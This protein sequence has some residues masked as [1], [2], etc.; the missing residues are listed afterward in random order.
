MKSILPHRLP[1]ISRPPLPDTGRRPP[2]CLLFPSH[3]RRRLASLFFLPEQGPF[4]RLQARTP[5]HGWSGGAG[6]S[7]SC[8]HHLEADIR[9]LVVGTCSCRKAALWMSLREFRDSSNHVS[10]VVT[11]S[12]ASFGSRSRQRWDFSLDFCL[13]VCYTVYVGCERGKSDNRSEKRKG[14]H[15]SVAGGH[16]KGQAVTY[17][18]RLADVHWLS[19]PGAR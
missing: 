1:P 15:R 11:K 14:G 9:P 18:E 13:L 19:G 17:T 10:A 12:T 5:A 4:L 7:G 6:A 3:L 8:E 2:R 16:Q